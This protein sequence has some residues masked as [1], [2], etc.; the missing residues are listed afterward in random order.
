MSRCLPTY[1]I[2]Y[3]FNKIAIVG[4]APGAEEEKQCQPF[5]GASGRE[6]THMLAD[7]GIVREEC[8]LTNVFMTRPPANN[9]EAWCVNKKE[10]DRLWN[11]LG[12]HGKYPFSGIKSGKYIKPCYLG[13]LKRLHTE[14]VEI[15]PN[16]IIVLGNA[17]LWAL[18]GD[19]GISKVRGTLIECNL[20]GGTRPFKVLP[21][22]HPA[23]ILRKWDERPIVVA[24]FTKAKK[25]SGDR[26]YI[27]PRRT[28]WLEPNLGD[29]RT[30]RD[31]Y[32][33]PGNP[34]SVDIE[35]ASGEI[36]CVGFGL[37]NTGICVP[38]LDERKP[39]RS[40]WPTLE[41]EVEAWGLIRQILQLPNVKILQNGMYDIQW[42]WRKM[43]IA[44]QGPIEDTMLLAHSMFP[45]MR[46]S[47]GFLGSIYTNESAWKR[48]RPRKQT[49][50][51]KDDAE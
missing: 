20:L 16:I 4:E 17:P 47:L 3:R 28:L 37:R 29:I 45:E 21:T 48:M 34:F 38:F 13:E 7:A 49:L 6:L 11:E 30:F 18:T 22:Y 23:Y 2:Q 33:V 27:R 41:E 44:V 35:T 39:G 12:N 36:T 24:D 9:L 50:Q 10:A 31:E 51:K 15:N 25:E 19:A 1:P 46:K 14:L 8:Y 32:L 26:T 5:V 42:L 43:G 40:Y